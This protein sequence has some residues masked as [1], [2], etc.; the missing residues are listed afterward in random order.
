M[1]VIVAYESLPNNS[2]G[3]I[4]CFNLA[5]AYSLLGHEVVILHKGE[6][7]SGDNPKII[8]FYHKN[9]LKRYFGFTD[10]VLSY[11]DD[12]KKKVKIEAVITYGY[13]RSIVQ[14]CSRNDV[15]CVADVVEW[16]SREQ[17]KRW[18]LSIDYLKKEY[19]IRH[20]AR[21]KVNVIAISSYL[22]QYFRQ[23]GCK[24]VRIP[25]L[26]E[27]SAEWG[28]RIIG[29]KKMRIIY[30]GSHLLMDNV[31]PMISTFLSLDIDVKKRVEFCIYGISRESI[32]KYLPE[33]ESADSEGLIKIYG[34]KPNE[35]VLE[36]YRHSHFSILLRD[37]DL[38]VNKA[39]FPSKVIESMKMGVPV[40]CNYSSDLA[41]YLKDGENSIIS[42]NIFPAE[43]KKAILK[44]L[45]LK[46]SEYENL[47]RN[48]LN[49][50]ER[51]FDISSFAKECEDIIR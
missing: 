4:R 37:P 36:A 42:D 41:L 49:T 5:R 23:Q 21:S 6:Y 15:K 19:D 11:L 10:R 39:G 8:S 26:A 24:T 46:S 16:Y 27:K 35:E 14:W 20:I 12:V 31:I 48:A 17:F 45:N 34:R 1:I 50:V 44:A 3:A 40:I 2:P 9:R 13:F 38:R 28:N 30:A 18:F 29:G 32:L 7:F 43:L 25:I 47:S 22:E 51:C 33:V